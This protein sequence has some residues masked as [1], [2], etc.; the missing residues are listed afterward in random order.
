MTFNRSDGFSAILDLEKNTV[1]Q[2]CG[3]V[4]LLARPALQLG[5][6]RILK[7][8]EG[9]VLFNGA[10]VT[11]ARIRSGVYAMTETQDHSARAY[12]MHL[13]TPLAYGFGSPKFADI[14]ER[15]NYGC[16]YI[17]THVNYPSDAVAKCYPFTPEEIHEGW[18]KGRERIVTNRSGKFGWPGSFR[19]RLWQYD[20]DGKRAEAGPAVREY[21]DD[22][23]LEVLPGGMSILERC[24]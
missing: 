11:R 18:V 15:L 21:R 5:M 6:D 2:E 12:A 9:F 20:R 17:R 16:L 10:P 23:E 1:K 8:P 24:D 19:A 13:T 22:A 3:V 4:P 7:K 14:V